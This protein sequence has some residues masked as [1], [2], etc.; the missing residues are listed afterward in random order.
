LDQS[1]ATEGDQYRFFF[2]FVFHDFH[3]DSFQ[4]KIKS[5]VALKIFCSLYKG[6]AFF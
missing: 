3:A 4:C 2:H 6:H 5:Y 1:V